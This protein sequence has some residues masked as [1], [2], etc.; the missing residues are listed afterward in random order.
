[1]S[2]APPTFSFVAACFR[3]STAT[4]Q[5]IGS[6]CLQLVLERRAR[7]SVE[8]RFHARSWIC[9][10]KPIKRVVSASLLSFLFALYA[11]IA[12]GGTRV[13]AEPELM[14]QQEMEV[15]VRIDAARTLKVDFDDVS[16][17]DVTEQT[18]PDENLGCSSR[19][20]EVDPKPIPGFR[21]VAKAK[22]AR[23][24]YHTDR[25]GLV[26]RC[27]APA[28]KRK[29]RESSSLERFHRSAV[30]APTGRPRRTSLVRS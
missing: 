18:W 10:K 8:R 23:V 19:E 7:L 13:K 15:R 28:K 2:Q 6:A 17:I 24:I 29:A 16:V 20:G 1:M 30:A 25:A 14:S 9:A 5:N 12:P 22:T 11:A 21:I 3:V 4:P 26:L 27:A